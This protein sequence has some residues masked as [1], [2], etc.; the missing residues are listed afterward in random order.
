M[1]QRGVEAL[2]GRLLTDH[3][4]R[5]RFYRD[6]AAVCVE[7]SLDVSVRELEA[8]VA[9]NQAHLATLSSHLDARIVRAGVELEA[10]ES[11]EN[12]ARRRAVGH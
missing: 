3:D 4:F 2:L 11:H 1:S 8:L 9:L 5:E 12:R 7:E 10:G 6:P